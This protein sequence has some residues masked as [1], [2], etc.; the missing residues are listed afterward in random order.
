VQERYATEQQLIGQIMGALQSAADQFGNSYESIF[1]DGLKT[2][3]E[4]YEFFRKQADAVAE[5]ITTLND[6]AA[7]SAAASE[8]NA[9]LMNAYNSLSEASQDAMRADI[10]ATTEQ[11]GA[12]VQDRLNMALENI[13]ADG[14][15]DV[16]GSVGNVIEAATDRAMDNIRRTVTEAVE[17]V[18]QQQAETSRQSPAL[19]NSLNLWA[20]NL[21]ENIRVQITGTEVAF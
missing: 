18:S 8:Y 10:L 2:E 3:Q 16:P 13:E 5:M 14:R 1:V 20:A 9:N 15:A 12:L 21:P 17:A 7:I 11:V 4:R 19:V 6:P